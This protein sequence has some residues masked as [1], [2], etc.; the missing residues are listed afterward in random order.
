[1]LSS[2]N[3]ELEVMLKF[4]EKDVNVW[5]LLKPG[6]H[7]GQYGKQAGSLRQSFGGSGGRA[8]QSADGREEEGREAAVHNAAQVG[9]QRY[10]DKGSQDAIASLSKKPHWKTVFPLFLSKDNIRSFSLMGQTLLLV[11]GGRMPWN[12]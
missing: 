2:W 5:F 9:I 7:T 8:H 11:K 6:E 3:T 1:M 4:L 12:S 10:E